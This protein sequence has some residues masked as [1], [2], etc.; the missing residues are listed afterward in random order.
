VWVSQEERKAIVL[1][2]VL[3]FFQHSCQLKLDR[4]CRTAS[5]PLTAENSW[6]CHHEYVRDSTAS[7]RV[8]DVHTGCVH[9][10]PRSKVNH[11]A[12]A[13]LLRWQRGTPLERRQ[14]RHVCWKMTG[15]GYIQLSFYLFCKLELVADA[16]ADEWK[17]AARPQVVVLHKVELM[18]HQLVLY[19]KAQYTCER[20]PPASTSPAGQLAALHPCHVASVHLAVHLEA[21][22]QAVQLAAVPSAVPAAAASWRR[23]PPPPPPPPHTSPFT[24]PLP[25]PPCL[26][27]S[28]FR[29]PTVLPPLMRP[30]V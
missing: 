26:L 1:L 3:A 28:P 20:A 24:P 27:Q 23:A 12:W 25:P 19:L 4:P 16:R 15:G 6:V 5:A 18:L 22:H 30:R 2:V 7:K 13:L 11:K 8:R 17:T 9:P 29:S 14:H 10:P 21:V